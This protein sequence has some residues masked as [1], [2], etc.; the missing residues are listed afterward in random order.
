MSFKTQQWVVGRRCR[1]KHV[2]A[3][4]K[5]QYGCKE[6]GDLCP[7]VDCLS[8]DYLAA[9]DRPYPGRRVEK[10]EVVTR[11]VTDSNTG[12]LPIGRELSGDDPADILA[13]IDNAD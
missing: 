12:P 8:S 3:A 11:C 4:S 9:T 6:I 2:E 10:T 13:P 5:E 7:H 1:Q